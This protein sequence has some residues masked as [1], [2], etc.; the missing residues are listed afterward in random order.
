MRGQNITPAEI[1]GRGAAAFGYGAVTVDAAGIRH[2]HG[3]DVRALASAR[4]NFPQHGR[5]RA[6]GRNS[7]G[8]TPSGIIPARLTQDHATPHWRGHEIN[9]SNSDQ[10]LFVTA[11][12]SG[13]A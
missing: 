10:V 1:A 13:V 8:M 9:P 3:Y 11:T 6:L 5:R 4:F 2:G 12:E 7:G